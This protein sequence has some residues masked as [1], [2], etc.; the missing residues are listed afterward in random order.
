MA[1]ALV[2]GLGPLKL[3]STVLAVNNLEL[4]HDVASEA[5]RHS[6][7]EFASV[8][9]VPGAAPRISFSTPFYEAYALIGLKSLK[10][11]VAEIYFAKFVDAVR[12]SG[13]VHRKYSLAASAVGHAY[14]KSVSVAQRGI[15]MAEVEVVFLSS[16]SMTHP[17]SSS[18]AGTLP[19]L[20]GEPQLYT[21]GPIGIN[22]TNYGSNTQCGLQLGASMSADATD[23]SLYPT[24]A[25]YHGGDPIISVDYNDP[26]TING[27]IGQTGTNLTSNFVQYFKPYNATTHVATLASS[28]SLTIASGRIIPEP[29]NAGN[30][31]MSR[32]SARIIGLSTSATHPWVIATGAS[33]PTP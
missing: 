18:D 10:I 30:L 21:L 25:A 28:L 27:A 17:L 12:Q 11:T 6:G 1:A 33:S 7:N 29:W 26:A 5:F 22:G 8:L 14:I 16:D 31:A 20:S 23:G 15:L 13:G 9:T 4:P 19:T 3:N 2:Y 32:G 24:V